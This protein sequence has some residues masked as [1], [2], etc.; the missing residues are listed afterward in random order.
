LDQPN[1]QTHR[2]NLREQTEMTGSDNAGSL[3]TA[4]GPEQ[5]PVSW[6]DVVPT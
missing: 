2:R 3:S 1:P 5:R 6:T 4:A